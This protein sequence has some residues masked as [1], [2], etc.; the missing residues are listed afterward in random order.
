MTY[1]NPK[2]KQRP[3]SHDLDMTRHT[4]QMQFMILSNGREC[5]VILLLSNILSNRESA[6]LTNALY[7]IHTMCHNH[8]S[9]TDK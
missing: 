3:L 5:D 7:K 1:F 9:A 4:Q 8:D 2:T 6:N